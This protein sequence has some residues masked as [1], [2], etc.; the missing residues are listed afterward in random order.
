MSTRRAP[1][2]HSRFVVR[3]LVALLACVAGFAPFTHI[4]SASAAPIVHEDGGAKSPTT[5]TT[6][7]AARRR[8]RARPRLWRRTFDTRAAL[9]PTRSVPL[10]DP[11]GATALL[12][13]LRL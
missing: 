3:G 13:V 5:A 10:H 11:A 7:A 8:R 6:D 2:R 12:T 4:V 1:R 9:A